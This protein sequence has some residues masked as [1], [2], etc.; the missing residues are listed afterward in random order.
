M[1]ILIVLYG[2]F[3]AFLPFYKKSQ[4]KPSGVYLAFVVA[5]ALEMFGVPMSMYI[6]AWVFGSTLPD[7]ILWGHTLQPYIGAMIS[8]VGV[9]L[10][11]FGWK[12]IHREYWSKEEG[13]GRLV[14]HGIYAYIAIRST[15]V[16]FSSR[17][18]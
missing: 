5:Y 10:V 18:A 11:I 9:L 1:A 14:T 3:L 17:S 13:K 6:L 16:F 4:V 8:I 15:P 12:E 2:V 7:G